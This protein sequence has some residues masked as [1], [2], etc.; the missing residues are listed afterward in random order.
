MK[1][2]ACSIYYYVLFPKVLLMFDSSKRNA[3]TKLYER[4]RET[5]H[6]ACP[7]EI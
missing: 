6:N 2:C 1:R 7:A 5:T 4:T 3:K